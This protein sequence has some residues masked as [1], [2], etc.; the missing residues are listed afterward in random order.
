MSFRS[1]ASAALRLILSAPAFHNLTSQAVRKSFIDCLKLSPNSSNPGIE[2]SLTTEVS[3][4]LTVDHCEDPCLHAGS[5]VFFV[6]KVGFMGYLLLLLHQ[7]DSLML[8]SSH[9]C[10]RV[11]G[12]A[13]YLWSDLGLLPF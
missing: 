1:S 11:S 7:S 9:G 10:Y 13:L 2:S 3:H 8:G 6:S 4:S 5:C 12:G